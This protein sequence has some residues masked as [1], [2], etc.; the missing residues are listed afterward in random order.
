MSTRQA[1]QVPV[2][3][4]REYLRGI[5]GRACSRRNKRLLE[6]GL[7]FVFP[8]SS[9]VLVIKWE[10]N[11]R[12]PK[13]TS[14]LHTYARKPYTHTRNSHNCEVEDEVSASLVY[15][16]V[17]NSY[18]RSLPSP[19]LILFLYVFPCLFCS[20]S[21]IYL[22]PPRLRRSLAHLRLKRTLW[23]VGLGPGAGERNKQ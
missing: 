9:S 14:T 7:L 2:K 20:C 11:E 8:P 10:T 23:V 4:K 16:L 13:S 18:W 1:V 15:K 12:T 6:R 5:Q 22:H 17:V 3:S 21:L 19:P